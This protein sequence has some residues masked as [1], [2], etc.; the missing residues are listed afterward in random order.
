MAKQINIELALGEHWIIDFNLNDEAGEDID[1][2]G[3]TV[4]F[5]MVENDVEVLS[6]SSADLNSAIS[7][8]SPPM[9]AGDVVISPDLQLQ[10]NIAPGV[11]PYAIRAT[12][13]DYRVTTQIV[14]KL[15][16]LAKL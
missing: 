12:L 15:F 16:I 14:G 7:I 5:M 8:D 11:Y 6:L 13:A 3:A 10:T 1:L 2:T 4:E 9:G